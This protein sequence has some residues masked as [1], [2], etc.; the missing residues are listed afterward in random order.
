MKIVLFI[1]L[2]SLTFGISEKN[3]QQKY[4]QIIYPYVQTFSSANFKGVANKQVHYLSKDVGAHKGAIVI[5]PGKSEP[6][7]RYAE[8]AYDLKSQG[9]AIYII[10]HRG[11]GQS[12]RLLSDGSDKV[13][14]DRFTDYVSDLKTFMDTVVIPQKYK[15][16]V[17]LGHSMGGAIIALYLE[18]YKQDVAGAILSA[19]MLQ[20]NTGKYPEKF[21]YTVTSFLSLIGLEKTY[22]L[23]ET[24]WKEKPFSER[25]LSSSSVR[26]WTSEVFIPQK[27]P[28]TISGGATNRWVKESIAATWRAKRNSFKIATPILLL[29]AGNDRLSVA[30]GQDAFLSKI[31]LSTK[32]V[33]ASSRHGILMETDIIRNQALQDVIGFIRSLPVNRP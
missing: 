3:Y 17:F 25:S 18:K 21:A 6:A 30:A 9:Y 11:M 31:K 28:E 13:Y 29:Q 24:K 5:V 20:I 15:K 1:V 7:L 8:I 27:H 23:G 33:Y 14:V 26:Y 19:P 12:A 10:D 16:V 4:T 32:R 2:I 22:A